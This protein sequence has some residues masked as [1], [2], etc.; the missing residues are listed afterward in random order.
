MF[1][2]KSAAVFVRFLLFLIFEF[3]GV[4]RLKVSSGTR[5]R[6]KCKKNIFSSFFRVSCLRSCVLSNK[7]EK[8]LEHELTCSWQTSEEEGKRFQCKLIDSWKLEATWDLS[9]IRQANFLQVF[10]FLFFK[11]E[12]H[13]LLIMKSRCFLQS[14]LAHCFHATIAA[15]L[16]SKQFAFKATHKTFMDFFVY[17]CASEFLWHD[18]RKKKVNCMTENGKHVGMNCCY[19]SL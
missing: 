10:I 3:F 1:H 7:K 6:K 5:C 9:H 17:K 8:R 16:I 19:K 15:F 12:K 4:R 13:F 11:I 14:T 18:E 2:R